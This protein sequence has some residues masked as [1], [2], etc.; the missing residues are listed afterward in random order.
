M[1]LPCCGCWS[2]S[3]GAGAVGIP[4]SKPLI[5]LHHTLQATMS[6]AGSLPCR[7]R[8][9]LRRGSSS[10]GRRGWSGNPIGTVAKRAISHV[11]LCTCH[12]AWRG[13]YSRGSPCSNETSKALG[14]VIVSFLHIPAAASIGC[15]RARA[16]MIPDSSSN[17]SSS[18]SSSG[19]GS[20]SMLKM[21]MTLVIIPTQCNKPSRLLLVLLPPTNHS[22]A[23]HRHPC[24]SP[25]F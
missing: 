7:G 11:N 1:F 5:N 23:I 22:R 20:S 19:S 21:V 9:G 13:D 12:E 17:S 18:S 3:S 25:S 16:R 10:G 14:E 6:D 15:T 4:N 24:R 2:R 8:R